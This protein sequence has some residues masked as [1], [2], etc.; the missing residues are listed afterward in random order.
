MN[1]IKPL[2]FRLLINR[3]YQLENSID[4]LYILNKSSVIIDNICFIGST[5][6]SKCS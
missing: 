6:W 3:L 1:N 5:L 4:N 2:P